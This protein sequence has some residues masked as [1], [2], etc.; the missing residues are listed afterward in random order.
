MAYE[1]QSWHQSP[2]LGAIRLYIQSVFSNVTIGTNAH[3]QES[4]IWAGRHCLSPVMIDHARQV[5]E[6]AW[7]PTSSCSYRL[8]IELYH[9]ILIG[10]VQ[11]ITD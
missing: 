1:R 6:F 4:A 8:I 10:D 7:R 5:G 11:L 2:R 3:V 9:R